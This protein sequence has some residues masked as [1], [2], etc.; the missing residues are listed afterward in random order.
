[1]TNYNQLKTAALSGLKRPLDADEIFDIAFQLGGQVKG[2]ELKPKS[3]LA[4]IKR[5]LGV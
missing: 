2:K 5:Y 3:L 1:M 4:R